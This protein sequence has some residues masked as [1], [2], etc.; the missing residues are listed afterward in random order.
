MPSRVA[1]SRVLDCSPAALAGARAVLLE[2]ESFTEVVS[3]LL[4]RAHF[5]AEA[6]FS[7]A[8]P[9]TGL[10]ARQQ[11]LLI[12]VCQ[13]PGSTQNQLA[14]L[15]ALDRNSLAEM[16][17]RMERKGLLTRKKSDQ[18]SRCR[19]VFVTAAGASLLNR[20]LSHRAKVEASIIEAVPTEH[21]A[22]FMQCLK[23]LA[24]VDDTV[25]TGTTA[26]HAND[27][28]SSKPVNS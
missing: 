6:A 26:P 8:A 14:A 18:D 28:L 4:R 24:G 15:I 25:K 10:T 21:R 9:D 17:S 12:A 22:V 11:A 2:A 27:S 16:L 13:H 7:H 3:H 23:H 1:A 5:R 20:I 19:T